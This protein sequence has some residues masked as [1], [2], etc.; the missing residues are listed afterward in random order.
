MFEKVGV[1][2]LGLVENMSFFHC[3]N[4]GHDAAVF[5][6]GGAR[7]EAAR[8]A[9]PFLGE[10][11]LLLD[12]RQAGDAG[13]PIILAAPDSAGAVAFRAIAHRAWA[14]IDPHS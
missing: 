14:A 10:V 4:C 6:H 2:I 3:P 13:R 9:V 1:R 8:L 12:V 5:G 11:P 7:T